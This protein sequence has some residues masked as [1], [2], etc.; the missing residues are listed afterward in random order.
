MKF[1]TDDFFK[2]TDDVCHSY[3]RISM[4]AIQSTNT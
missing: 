4:S 1:S 2:V 3:K